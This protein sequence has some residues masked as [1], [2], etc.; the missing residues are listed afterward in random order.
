MK[1]KCV[2]K[3]FQ[4]KNNIY[5]N[6][7]M[8][9]TATMNKEKGKGNGLEQEGERRKKGRSRW[10][11]VVPSVICSLVKERRNITHDI[12]I[13]IFWTF[14]HGN[15]P[16]LHAQRSSQFCPCDI[17]NYLFENQCSPILSRLHMPGYPFRSNYVIDKQNFNRIRY[18]NPQFRAT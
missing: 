5:R 15:R 13:L 11:K 9:V 7:E 8:S 10:R 12:C 18:L 16:L 4:G 17:T 3:I 14:G 6:G 1:A 2:M